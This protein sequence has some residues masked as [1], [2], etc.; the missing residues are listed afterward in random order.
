MVFIFNT[1]VA[2]RCIVFE[3]LLFCHFGL[4]DVEIGLQERNGQ[5]EVDIIQARGLTPKPGSKTL[6]GSIL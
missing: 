2:R 4:G 6:P 1:S 5:L 3:S